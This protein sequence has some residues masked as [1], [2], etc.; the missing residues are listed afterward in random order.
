MWMLED[1]EARISAL[2]AAQGDYRAVLAAVNALGLNQREH[3]IRLTS[4]ETG[5]AEFRQEARAR[6]RSVDEHLVEIKDLI[7]GR[8]R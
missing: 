4:V 3:T 7:V 1:H 6:F 2:E 5:L 8:N